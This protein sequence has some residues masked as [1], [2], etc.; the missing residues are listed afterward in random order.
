MDY[1]HKLL[2]Y[3]IILNSSSP[4]RKQLLEDI[5]F[6]VVINKQ[7]ISEKY[8][9]SLTIKEIPEY[10]AQEKSN[11]YTNNIKS[12]EIVLSSDTLVFQSKNIMCK[13]KNLE[14]ARNMLKIL[15][16]NWHSVIT[17]CAIKTNVKQVSFSQETKVKFKSLSDEEIDYYLATFSPLDKAGAYGIQE[18]IGMIGIEEIQGDFYNVMGLPTSKLYEELIKIIQ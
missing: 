18:F 1:L 6:K 8:P 11:A 13:P 16:N 4:R 3:T 15:S 2:S 10:I 9:D 7:Q 5:G 14:D 17:A 12:N